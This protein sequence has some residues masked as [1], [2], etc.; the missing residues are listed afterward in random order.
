MTSQ[1]QHFFS[2]LESL[3]FYMDNYHKLLKKLKVKSDLKQLGSLLKMGI[4]PAI[5]QILETTE[6][7]A[8]VVTNTKREIVWT[9]NGFKE[10]TGY[11]KGFALGKRPSSFLQGTRTSEAKRVEIRKLLQ[12]EKR[13][14]AAITNYRKNGEEYVC[15]IEVLP[16]Y[17]S[18]KKL[19]HFLAMEYE[20]HA[21]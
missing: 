20:Q 13:F 17:D 6:Y 11:A 4:E 8:L 9:N 18:K 3:D 2:P 21:A 1:T 14:K 5:Q 7:E 16:L 15:A 19:T 12:Q 10:M